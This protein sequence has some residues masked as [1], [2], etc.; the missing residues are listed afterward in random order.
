MLNDDKIACIPPV[1]NDNRLA[2]DF[3]KKANLF[4]SFWQ[5]AAQLLRITVFYPHQLIALSISTKQTL[6]S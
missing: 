6:N 1:I 3:S 4:N 2:K 5:K